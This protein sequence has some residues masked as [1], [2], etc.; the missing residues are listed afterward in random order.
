MKDSK[1]RMAGAHF[2]T[3]TATAT[4]TMIRP[5]VYESAQAFLFRTEPILFLQANVKSIGEVPDYGHNIAM[6]AHLES[7]QTEIR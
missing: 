7:G 6:G 4:A 2:T 5:F 1:A 3:E